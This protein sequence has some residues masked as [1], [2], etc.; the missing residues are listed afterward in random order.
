MR[1]SES[2]KHEENQVTKLDLSGRVGVLSY[3]PLPLPKLHIPC[4]ASPIAIAKVRSYHHAMFVGHSRWQAG[5]HVP[6]NSP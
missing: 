5:R 2:G 3:F 1:G 6:S 4:A